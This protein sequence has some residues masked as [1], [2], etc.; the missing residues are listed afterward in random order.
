[1]LKPQLYVVLSSIRVQTEVYLPFRYPRL[2]S[3]PHDWKQ[4]NEHIAWAKANFY[5]D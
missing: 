3:K 2:G 4:R 1:M 5:S